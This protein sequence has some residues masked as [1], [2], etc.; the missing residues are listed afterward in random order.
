M[1]K[2]DARSLNTEAKQELRILAIKMVTSGKT[3]TEVANILEICRTTVS[4]WWCRYKKE[5]I[6]SLKK[7]TQGR[8]IGSGSKLTSE[9]SIDIQKAIIDKTPD[10]YQMSFS[11][12]NR[13][14]VREFIYKRY[15][16]KYSLNRLSV[17][18][19][20]WGFT[21]QKPKKLAYERNE[22]HVQKWLKEEYP[23]IAKEAKIEGSE[24]MWLDETCMKA[25]EHYQRGF[26]PKGKTPIAKQAAK[27]LHQS[28]I[29]AISNEGKMQWMALSKAL[30]IDQFERFLNQ[31]LKYRRRKIVLIM[32]NL[33]VHHAKKIKEWLIGKESRIKFEYLPSYSPELN[34]AE[35]GNQALKRKV[36]RGRF[37]KT[38]EAF[39]EKTTSVLKEMQSNPKSIKSLFDKEEVKY[40]K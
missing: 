3:Q 27:R 22:A 10:Q 16:V 7:N 29:S 4:M 33:R 21:P 15:G 19:A 26:S 11:L 35:Y 38:Q 24:I 13:E 36:G 28:I 32:D 39:T 25:Y 12:W 23:T 37:V 9:Q 2:R 30:N 5:G 31:L 1:I 14:A 34:P 6:K 17:L 40:A 8:P 18:L 20:E